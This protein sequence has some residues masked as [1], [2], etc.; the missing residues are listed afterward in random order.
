MKIINFA[1]S[2]QWTTV[3]R[4]IKICSALVTTAMLV[5]GTIEGIMAFADFC[6]GSKYHY[7]SK[8]E[9]LYYLKN[10]YL[11]SAKH[12]MGDGADFITIVTL[13]G[14]ACLWWVSKTVYF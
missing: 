9:Y 11:S 3:F 10:C 14:V 6:D 4:A 7:S 12:T 8:V 1:F 13:S 5:A 2:M